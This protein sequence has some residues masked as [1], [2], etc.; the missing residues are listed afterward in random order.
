MQLISIA[1]F[2]AVALSA[3][4]EGAIIGTDDRIEWHQEPRALLRRAARATAAII[5][6]G[7]PWLVPHRRGFALTAATPIHGTYDNLCPRERFR[8]QPSPSH[9]TGFLVAPDLLVTA[10]HCLADDCGSLYF[11][12]DFL[13]KRPGKVSRRFSNAKVYTCREIVASHRE[14]DWAVVRLDRPAVGR[15]TLR[16]RSEGVAVLRTPLVM[17]GYPRGVPLKLAGNAR[18]LPASGLVDESIALEAD[19]DSFGGNS[20]SPVLNENT[21]EVEGILTTAFGQ[22]ED[23]EPNPETGGMCRRMRT[24]SNPEEATPAWVTRTSRF[25]PSLQ[26]AQHK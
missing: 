23:D 15:P 6:R 4:V 13:S 8:D 19:L 16:L 7:E 2:I 17:I 20:G 18:V 24:F 25:L 22:F 12:F 5:H 26:R 11:L 9:C 14:E 21:L 3:S 1:L 10:A